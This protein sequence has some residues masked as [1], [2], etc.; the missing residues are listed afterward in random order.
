MNNNYYTNKDIER[1]FKVTKQTVLHW[2]KQGLLPYIAINKRKFL[3]KKED[4]EKL[5][6]IQDDKNE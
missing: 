5:L 2:R 6:N 4:V 3:Y 1:L